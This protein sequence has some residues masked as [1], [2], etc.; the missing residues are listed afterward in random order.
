MK[1]AVF[2][3]V[4]RLGICLN[5]M[6][7]EYDDSAPQKAVNE[8]KKQTQKEKLLQLKKLE[9][10]KSMGDTIEECLQ[11]DEN[12]I[13][14]KGKEEDAQK[15]VDYFNCL[16][17][18]RRLN[19]VC[20]KGQDLSAKK[21]AIDKKIAALEEELSQTSLEVLNL[22]EQLKKLQEQEWTF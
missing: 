11:S 9:S 1:M 6:M 20:N 8:K 10:T 5:S 12:L 14:I 2:L 22:K 16:E 15:L 18:Q 21:Q 17:I 7:N 3:S 4:Q 19:S 13:F